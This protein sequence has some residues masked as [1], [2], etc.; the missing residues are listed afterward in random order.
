VII[1]FDFSTILITDIDISIKDQDGNN[2][3]DLCKENEHL[4]RLLARDEEHLF[5]AVL[6]NEVERV[7]EL[8]MSFNVNTRFVDNFT[9][10]HVAATNNMKD[11]AEILIDAGIDLD[12]VV[13]LFCFFLCFILCFVAA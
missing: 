10:L 8:V 4:K 9:L 11:I 13:C 6:Y 2:A 3:F 5:I 7:R 12:T 1:S